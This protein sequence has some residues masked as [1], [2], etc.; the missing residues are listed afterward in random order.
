MGINKKAA[1]LKGLV[2]G[3]NLDKSKDEVKILEAVVDMIQKL[4]DEIEILKND[5]CENKELIYELDDDLGEVERTM[6]ECKGFKGKNK[7]KMQLNDGCSTNCRRVKVDDFEG[8]YN[9]DDEYFNDNVELNDDNNE[10]G[11]EQYEVLCPHCQQLISL[12]DGSFNEKNLL[13]PQCGKNLEFDFD[14]E[15]SNE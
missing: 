5:C 4:S 8:D 9:A 7:C 15:K 10:A 12:D 14:E 6:C 1:Y 3:M 11:E 13:C 2:E